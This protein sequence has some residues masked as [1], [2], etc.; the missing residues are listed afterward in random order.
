[1]MV[2]IQEERMTPE[3]FA[4]WLQGLLEGNP[5]ILKDGLTAT[6]TRII[7]DHL[8]LVFNKVT[9]ERTQTTTD[10]NQLEL[11][12]PDLDSVTLKRGDYTYTLLPSD[13]SEPAIYC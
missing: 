6:Q 3:N 7:Q 9:P 8:N 12:F 13:G 10:G 2:I 11:E 1:M 5:Q 4:Y